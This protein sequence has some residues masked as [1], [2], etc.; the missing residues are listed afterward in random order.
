MSFILILHLLTP[1]NVSELKWD[2]TMHVQVVEF[3]IRFYFT[4][5]IQLLMLL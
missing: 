1:N 3:I 4:F 5:K 2:I